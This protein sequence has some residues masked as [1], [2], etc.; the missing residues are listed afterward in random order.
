MATTAAAVAASDEII[1]DENVR[2]PAGDVHAWLRAPTRHCAAW[3]LS[4]S[5]LRVG[6]VTYRQEYTWL[7]EDDVTTAIRPRLG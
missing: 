7:A 5:R 3:A 6:A 1:D 4:R 2:R